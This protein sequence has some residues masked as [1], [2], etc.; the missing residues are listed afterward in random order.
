MLKLFKDK[1][2][3]DGYDKED[4]PVERLSDDILKLVNRP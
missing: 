4:D 3:G 2:N 1:N